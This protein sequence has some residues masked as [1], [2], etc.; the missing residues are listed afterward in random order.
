MHITRP[1]THALIQP[2]A[3]F[4]WAGLA[5]MLT[6]V[7]IVNAQ[8]ALGNGRALEKQLQT[9]NP[10]ARYSSQNDNFAREMAFREAVVTGTAP[11]GLSFQ[12]DALP[13]RFEFRGDLGSD[14]IFSFRR[15]SLSSGLAGRGIRGTEALQYQFPPILPTRSILFGSILPESFKMSSLI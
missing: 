14:A 12:G 11:G 6:I 2:R 8:N 15:D 9:K 13:S 5:S 7:P 3:L 4:V 10:N 1:T